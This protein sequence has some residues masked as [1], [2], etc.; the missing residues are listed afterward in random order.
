[1]TTTT[2][3][4]Y[5]YRFGNGKA[6]GNREQKS[7]LGGKGANLNE[8]SS[9]GLPVPPGCTI[10]TEACRYYV[11]NDGDWPPG[12]EEEVR[13]GVKHVEDAMGRRFGDASNPLLLSVRSG[14]ALSMP[15]M[16]DT[17]L[18]LGINDE[19]AEGFA[20]STGNERLAFDAYRRF[21]DM[22]GDVVVGIDRSLFE[23]AI[24]NMK[25]ERGADA[26]VE[27]TGS[28]LR[29]LVDRYKAIYRKQTGRMFPSDPY[30]QLHLAINA[31]FGSWMNE[32]S[33]TYRRLNN[34]PAE[35]GTAVNVQAMVFG[36]MGDESATGVAFT[37]DP[38]TGEKTYYGE[39]LVNAQGED[40]VAGI[41]TP[42]GPLGH[43]AKSRHTA[44]WRPLIIGDLVQERE[45][46][47]AERRFANRCCFI[48]L[49]PLPWRAAT[50]RSGPPGFILQTG[51]HAQHLFFLRLR[52]EALADAVCPEWEAQ[53]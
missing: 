22:F 41:R 40:V 9:I 52:T 25:E 19:V 50:S 42:Q 48:L 5:V 31:V 29:D 10:T 35:W 51:E 46:A 43:S 53:R 18:N 32:R 2:N 17:V 20:E 45:Y 27:L 33:K 36:N 12:L 30:E 23:K 47:F 6:E 13:A 39:F 7:L 44:D 49:M 15:G 14:A 3:K 37:R 38:S 1:M 24:T 21:I 8:M 34:I 4:K 26:D 28:D 11:E 16:M